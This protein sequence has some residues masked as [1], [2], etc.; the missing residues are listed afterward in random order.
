MAHPRL[1]ITDREPARLGMNVVEVHTEED[2]GSL[3]VGVG[4]TVTGNNTYILM[5]PITQ[6]EPFLIDPGA[7]MDI[8]TRSLESNVLTYTNT[9]EAQFQGTGVTAVTLD[10][11]TMNG[12]GTGEMFDVTGSAVAFKFPV[13]LNY[14]SGGT[15]TSSPDVFAPGAVME[16]ATSGLSLVDSTGTVALTQVLALSGNTMTVFDISGASSGDWQFLSNIIFND[17]NSSFIHIDS[18]FPTTSVVDISH[19]NVLIT[20]NFFDGTSLDEMD[21]RVA[22]INNKGVKDSRSIGSYVATGNATAT[23]ISTSNTW[24]DINLNASAVAGSNIEGWTLTNTTTGELRIDSVAGFAG[25]GIASIS[26]NSVGGSQEF[27]FRFVV[28][29]SPLSD[30]VVSGVELG[31]DTNNVALLAPITGNDTDLIK[32]QVQNIDGTS[33]I[34]IQDISVS[35]K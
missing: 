25:E 3:S 12:N 11:I 22:A 26:C 34:T 30:G 5:D 1:N 16:F 7:G 27:Q 2:F 18:T 17:A 13:I 28:N 20:A 15:I 8:R 19:C 29:G 14:G 33:N 31:S 21:S 24:T 4:I 32:V 23:T 9:T 6:T 10:N 35:I